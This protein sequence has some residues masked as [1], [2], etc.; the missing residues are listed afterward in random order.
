MS[1]ETAPLHEVRLLLDRIARFEQEK[2]ALD[3][4]IAAAF[5][6]GEQLGWPAARLR[7][8][9][10]QRLT[11]KKLS[12]IGKARWADPDYR[13]R[14][15]PILRANRAGET[16]RSAA[17]KAVK[18]KWEHQHGLPYAEAQQVNRIRIKLSIS[19]AE[20]VAIHKSHLAARGT[21]RKENYEHQSRHP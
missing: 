6:A 15:L 17:L 14:M 21:P 18:L 3:E 20:A 13:A 11:N 7:H 8:V 16:A 5:A 4:K 12:A 9:L 19:M 10:G 1:N 2:A